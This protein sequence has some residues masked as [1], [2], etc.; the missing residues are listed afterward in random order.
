MA[1]KYLPIN[2]LPIGNNTC[3]FQFYFT[4]LFL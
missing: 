3:Y 2:K 1:I 4:S